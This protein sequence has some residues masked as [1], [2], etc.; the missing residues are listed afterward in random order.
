MGDETGLQSRIKQAVVWVVG[1]VLAVASV[2][3]AAHVMPNMG[4][5]GLT[6]DG[7]C[8]TTGQVTVVQ[9]LVVFAVVATLALIVSWET[10]RIHSQNKL[11]QK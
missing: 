6:C 11:N 3:I 5:G 1:I 9:Q 10:V 2:A 7:P 8:P 4:A